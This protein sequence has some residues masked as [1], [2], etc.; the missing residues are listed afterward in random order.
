MHC[1]D[2]AAATSS[3]DEDGSLAVASRQSVMAPR[4][5]ARDGGKQRG[6]PLGYTCVDW[7]NLGSLN[8]RGWG[9]GCGVAKKLGNEWRSVGDQKFTG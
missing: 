7:G 6:K 8:M 9:C 4:R 2:S 3:T 1:L 5:R